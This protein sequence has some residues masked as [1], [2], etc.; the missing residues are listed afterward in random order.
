MSVQT[1][2]TGVERREAIIDAAVKLFS[3]RGFRGVTTREIASEVGVTEPV[4]YQHFPSKRDLYRA[5]IER[6]M[7]QSASL[8]E[9]FKA[10]CEGTDSQPKEFFLDLGRLMVDWHTADPTFLRLM[11]LAK[12]EGHEL[13]E[14]MHGRMFQD[15]YHTLVGAI[16]RHMAC[17]KY[18]N[19]DPELA[20]YAFCAMIGHHC[21]DRL[22]FRRHPVTMRSDEE[23]IGT[24]VDIF[25][26]GIT[27]ETHE[28]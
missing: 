4:L 2:M 27:K 7:E 17:D 12:I 9:R 26:H 15:Y 1:R 23:V 13:A 8:G 24:I 14:I 21:L 20:A 5:I 22:I 11:M 18:R 28:S 16:R 19:I 10:I 25:L 3:E 6:K